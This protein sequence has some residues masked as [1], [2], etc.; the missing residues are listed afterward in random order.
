[1]AFIVV[2]LL[3]VVVDVPRVCYLSTPPPSPYSSPRLLSVASLLLPTAVLFSFAQKFSAA[4][5]WLHK[6]LNNHHTHP[7]A[8]P[9]P[10][11]RGKE[12]ERQRK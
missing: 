3:F 6:F 8:A 9:S 5:G 4:L 2:L 11:R 10:A 7:R 1:M 12:R